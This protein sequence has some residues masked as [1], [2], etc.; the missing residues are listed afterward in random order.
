MD[1]MWEAFI[2]T[3]VNCTEADDQ[4]V[5]LCIIVCADGGGMEPQVSLRRDLSYT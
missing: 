2:L 4:T 5:R 3:L 1:K